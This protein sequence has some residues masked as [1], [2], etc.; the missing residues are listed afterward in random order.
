[1]GATTATAQNGIQIGYGATATV[2][3]NYVVDD[4]YITPPNCN[5]CYGASGILI[6]GSA[7]V[8][9]LSNTVESTQYGIVPVTASASL[10][11]NGIVVTSNHIGGTQLYDAIDLCSNGNTADSNSIFGSNAQ[12]GVHVDDQCPGPGSTPSGT[13]NTVKN[14]TINEPCAGVLLG[15]GTPNTSSPNTF[16]NVR[17]TT[18]SGN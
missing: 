13:N 11:A 16:F 10:T 1:M 6:Y 2:T 14:N 4:I 9:V 5:P 17:F 3:S 7:G 12:S 8:N 18:L 15:S